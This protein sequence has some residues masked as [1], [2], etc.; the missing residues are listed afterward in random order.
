[1]DFQNLIKQAANNQVSK[2]KEVNITVFFVFF[3]VCDWPFLFVNCQLE[4]K[5]KEIETEKKLSKIQQ[6]EK[7]KEA[8]KK[9]GHY[10]Q[11][12]IKSRQVYHGIV[13]SSG[14]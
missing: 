6:I 8:K 5:K 14:S 7:K 13:S 9:L 10:E 1:M 4:T 11:E 3:G 2:Q 12:V